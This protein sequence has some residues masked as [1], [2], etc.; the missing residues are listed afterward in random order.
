MDILKQA[1]KSWINISENSYVIT[2]GK[3]KA[4]HTVKI[5]FENSDFYHLAG[6]QYLQD[7]QLLTISRP[8]IIFAI[9]DNRID[10]EYIQKGQNYLSLVEARLMALID[11]EYALDNDFKLFK[12][13]PDV[14]P[15]HTTI[16]DAEYLIEGKTLNN[17]LFFFTVKYDEAY[18]GMSIFMKNRN[19]DFSINHKQLAVLK[20]EKIHI[21]SQNKIVL[22]DKLSSQK[23][24]SK[25]P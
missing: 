11:L 17:S 16:K 9:L 12:Y 15:F 1:A 20:K 8:Q 7:L 25:E 4:L 2:Y 24:L 6:F 10:G 22:L 13:N 5:I 19:R 3:S 21:E 23:P 14:Y 18:S